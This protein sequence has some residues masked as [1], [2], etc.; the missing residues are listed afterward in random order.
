MTFLKK[1]FDFAILALVI[2][3]FV[4]VAADRLATVP[5]PDTDESMTLQI[6]YE[7]LNHGKLGFPM[8]RFYGGNIENAWHSLTPLAFVTL[9]GFL[10]AFGWGLLQGRAYTL[11]TS[12]LLLLMLYLLGRRLFSWQAG[13]CAV[14]LVISDPMFLARSRLVR[15]DILSAAFALLAFYLYEKA[16]DNESS[17]YYL[18]SGVAAGAGVMSHTNVLYIFGV[19]SAL[20]VLKDKWALFRKAKLYLFSAGALAAMGYEIVFAIVDHGNFILQNRKDDVHFRVLEPLGWLRNLATEPARY[21][22][23]FEAR[24]ARTTTE[25][26]L[27][28]FFLLATIVAIIYLIAIAVIRI[29]N[30]LSLNEPRVRLVIATVIIALFFAVVIQRKV[31]HYIVHLAPWFALCVAVLLRD[32]TDRI[33]RLRNR[34]WRW[35]KPVFA[36]ASVIVV[37]FVAAYGYELLRQN[38]NYLANVRNPEQASFEEVKTALRSIVPDELC[39]ASI[40]SGYVWLAFPERDDCYFAYMEASL[41]EPLDLVGKEYALI[42]KPKFEGRVLKLTGSR[43]ER[44]HLLGELRRTAYGTL[45]VYYTGNDPRFEASSP[46]RYYF[47]GRQRG[48]VGDEQLQRGV[49]VWNASETGFEWKPVSAYQTSAPDDA[50]EE[51]PDDGRRRGKLMEFCSVDLQPNSIYR[52]IVET[53][54]LRGYDLVIMNGQNVSAIDNISASDQETHRVDGVFKTSGNGR[55]GFAVRVAGPKAA[56]LPPISHIRIEAI[57]D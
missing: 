5:L 9:S 53:K 18:A 22:R 33:L 11:I 35:A 42:V 57:P 10:K 15:F 27:L 13:L 2:A 48:Y 25:T 37:I 32:V 45:L 3:G 40:A 43:F 20:M 24:G 8:M 7:M 49:E 39:P 21:V 34:E 28:H 30:R 50:E 41:D 31:T 36:G 52:V 51:S 29:R 16:Q 44:F 56:D 17:W 26:L 23:W 46:R 55:V 19:I 38:R 47:F 12:V 54:D 1:Y 4:Y 6:P 14:V